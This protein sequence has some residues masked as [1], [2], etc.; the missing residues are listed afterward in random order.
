M[1]LV[2]TIGKYLVVGAKL[3]ASIL[4]IVWDT[5]KSGQTLP[6][7]TVVLCMQLVCELVLGLGM[8]QGISMDDVSQK[9]WYMLLSFN[10]CI[11]IAGYALLI[12]LY[13]HSI[14]VIFNRKLPKLF[15]DSTA[16]GGGDD[17]PFLKSFHV[18]LAL[19][20]PLEVLFRY[21]T[22]NFRVLPDV[23]VLGEV[24]CGTTTLCQHISELPGCHTPFC[25]WKHPELD[26]KETFYFAGH[27]L[28][29][30]SPDKYRMCFPLKI[31]KWFYRKVLNRPFFTFDGSAQYLTSPTAPFLISKVYADAGLEPPVMIACVRD[32]VSQAVSWWRYEN[33]AMAW[34][35]SMGLDEWNTD[36]RLTR[37]PLRIL[38]ALSPNFREKF[39][40]MYE[41]K[42]AEKVVEA[43]SRTGYKIPDEMISWPGGQLSGIGR[44]GMF[45]TNITR[46]ENEFQSKFR[47]KKRYIT[48]LPLEDISSKHSLQCSLHFA[49][50]P[51]ANLVGVV[52]LPQLA[53][54]KIQRSSTDVSIDVPDEEEER[55]AIIKRN[56]HRNRGSALGDASKEPTEEDIDVLAEFFARDVAELEKMCKR[57]FS[58]W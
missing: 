18:H 35:E 9:L 57:S 58:N 51:K 56:I 12:L 30:M 17:F 8:T 37:A 44:N 29:Y 24:R 49:F 31:T 39:G 19:L 15:V 20:R 5:A 26:H 36:L 2:S 43:I 53:T 1:E 45:F 52:P 23:L 25:L 32:P 46:Y 40:G 11:N 16:S 14:R 28:G 55:I 47:T 54:V 38:D 13:R 21:A 27:Y 7:A 10:I 41:T 6:A 3:T 42:K 48:V 4:S 50:L 34:G 33:N 22:A